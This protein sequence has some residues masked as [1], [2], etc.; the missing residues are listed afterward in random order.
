MAFK[1]S[2]PGGTA[3]FGALSA[4]DCTVSGEDA[5]CL[6][7]YAV[8]RA[9]NKYPEKYAVFFQSDYNSYNR[10]EP[11]LPSCLLAVV[12]FQSEG[13]GMEEGDGEMKANVEENF[14]NL[15]IKVE[16]VEA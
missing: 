13:E 15:D 12:R 16:K 7:I 6:L 2:F 8:D 10:V 5:G 3:K 14:F 11:A 1:I 4:F 9:C